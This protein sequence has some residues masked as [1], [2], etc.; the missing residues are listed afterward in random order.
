MEDLNLLGRKENSLKNERKIMQTISKD[1]NMNF[2]LGKRERI[3]LKRGSVK[4]K[5]NEGTTLKNLTEESIYVFRH[6][7]EF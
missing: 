5:L 2:G 7:R 3:C 1:I 6:R 4:R